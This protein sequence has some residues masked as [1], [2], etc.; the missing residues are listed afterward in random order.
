M[1][2]EDVLKNLYLSIYNI[3]QIMISLKEC[4]P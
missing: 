4:E 3:E 2:P 1:L